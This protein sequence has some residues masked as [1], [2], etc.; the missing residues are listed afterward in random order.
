MSHKPHLLYRQNYYRDIKLHCIIEWQVPC[1]HYE[2]NLFADDVLLY[3][4]VSKEE[5]FALVQEAVS[6]LDNWSVDN[7][8]NFNLTKCKYII[9][10]RKLHPTLPNTP[11][12]L[13]N[14]R[15]NLQQLS[16]ISQT[17]QHLYSC[18]SVWRM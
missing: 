10:S 18:C 3:H 14:P 4:V 6:L 13:S 5:D 17:E 8:L 11:L 9:I 1:I 16:Y 7:H 2:V 15:G 12:L